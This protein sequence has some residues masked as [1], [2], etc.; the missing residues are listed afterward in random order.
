MHKSD[1]TIISDVDN[2]KINYIF[3]KDTLVCSSMNLD[4]H[5]KLIDKVSDNFLHNF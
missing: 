5:Q 4:Q 3:V 2:L 1:I